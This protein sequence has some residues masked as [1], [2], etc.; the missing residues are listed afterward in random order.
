MFFSRT[1]DEYI[2]RHF[3]NYN[4]RISAAVGCQPLKILR[5]YDKDRKTT[6]VGETTKLYCMLNDNRFLFPSADEVESKQIVVTTLEVSLFLISLNIK[7]SFT[8]IFID[9]A[10]Q[11]YECRTIMPLCLASKETCIVVAGGSHPNG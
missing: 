7:G 5:I 3:H 2:V 1:A 4:A 6:T 11:D 10:A 9:E 8:H